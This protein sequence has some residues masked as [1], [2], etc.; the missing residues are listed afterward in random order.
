VVGQITGTLDVDSYQLVK[1]KDPA[2]E[3]NSLQAEDYLNILASSGVPSG[4]FIDVVNEQRTLIGEFQEPLDN[5]GTNPLTVRV[6]NLDKTVEYRGPEDP[7]GLAD[8]SIIPGTQTS[9]LTIQR[10]DNSQIRSGESVLVD[11][12]H[13]ENFTVTYI[14]N[15][16]VET[17]QETLDA[18][19]HIASDNLIK[20]AIPAPLD[21]TTTV[22]YEEGLSKSVVEQSI[23][24]NLNAFVNRQRQ[25]SRISPS[26][27]I[28]QIQNTTGINSV[29]VP[30]TKFSRSEGSQVVRESILTDSVFLLGTQFFPLSNNTV[31]VYLLTDEFEAATSDGGGSDE[32]FR[33][34]YQDE[35]LLVLRTSDPFQIKNQ[36]GQSYIIG[37]E[38]LSIPGYSD[39]TTILAQFPDLTQTE[40]DQKRAEITGNRALVS[41]P[42]GDRPELHAYQVTYTVAFVT[43]GSKAIQLS[44]LEYFTL[45]GEI[46]LTL[47]ENK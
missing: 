12:S 11:Y 6:Y 15:Q 31:S 44:N 1:P 14:T 16:V 24:T 9:P 3:G 27:I 45:D 13:V 8:F 43:S 39:D 26:Q 5:L 21:I 23:L 32:L 47:V 33:G 36:A 30:L 34:V 42:V 4:D 19:T 35:E 41:L 40:I 46:L 18:Q 10:T 38:G 29:S 7:S 37:Q 28:A 22:T 17:T 2:L 25:G 20:E